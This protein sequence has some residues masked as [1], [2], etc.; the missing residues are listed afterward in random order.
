MPR[1][2]P[3]TANSATRANTAPTLIK[4]ANFQ[5]DE[6]ARMVITLMS[7]DKASIHIEK[8]DFRLL[9]E[10]NRQLEESA[11]WNPD[12]GRMNG[13][14]PDYP[15][16]DVLWVR[17]SGA[18]ISNIPAKGLSTLLKGI[19]TFIKNKHLGGDR[20]IIVGMNAETRLFA[21]V[22]QEW[23]DHDSVKDC[24][25]CPAHQSRELVV[26]TKTFNAGKWEY[27]EGLFGHNNSFYLDS[28]ETAGIFEAAAEIFA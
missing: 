2:T 11:T 9:E 16:E 6:H 27:A 8:Q 4:Q 1:P 3:I 13:D 12:L 23:V 15:G 24:P 14:Y 17:S 5:Y 26:Y 20:H 7:N 28:P 10:Y 18:E 22:T 19:V 21:I 25:H